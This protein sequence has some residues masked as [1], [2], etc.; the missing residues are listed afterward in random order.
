MFFNSNKQFDNGDIKVDKISIKFLKA[1]W[2][3][4]FLI[5]FNNI[6]KTTFLI[7]GGVTRAFKDNIIG[8]LKQEYVTSLDNYI[9]LT[10]IDDDH[11]GGIEYYFERHVDLAN[12]CNGIIFNTFDCLLK[13]AP[14]AKDTPPYIYINDDETGYTS[15]RQGKRLEQKLEE[16]GI[17]VISDIVSE[18]K[19]C[20]DGIQIT[21]LSPSIESMSKY[22]SWKDKQEPAYTAAKTSDYMKAIEDLKD[23]HFCED[24]SPTN[25]SSLSMLIEYEGM[26]MLFLGDSLP[27]DVVSALEK[28]GYSSEKKLKVDVVKVSHHGSKENTSHEL[29]KMITCNKFLISTDGRRHGHPDKETLARIIYSQNCP[30]LIF[31]YDIYKNIFSKEELQSGLFTVN[32][33]EEVVLNENCNTK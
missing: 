1:F 25:S 16:N 4:C 7:D 24:D 26:K 29:L 32:L 31:N 33:L 6:K 5:K 21:F 11:I 28:V 22:K 8:I 13:L 2:G 3:D 27:T 14:N 17:S 19:I 12:N 23:I 9:F 10:H 30:E 18:T 20:L 15:Y